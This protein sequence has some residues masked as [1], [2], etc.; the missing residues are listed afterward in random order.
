[1]E[2]VEFLAQTSAE[3]AFSE[4]KPEKIAWMACHFSPYGMGLSNLPQTL[5]EG[6][7]L[8]LNDR[9]PICSHDP[10]LIAAQLSDAVSDFSCCAV[11]LDFQR[12]G[13]DRTRQVV[14]SIIEAHPC[15]VGVS[16]LYAEE[17]DC[18]VFLPPPDLDKPLRD[19]LAPWDGREIWLEAALDMAR[20]TVTEKG[21]TSLPLPYSPPDGDFFKDEALCCSYRCDIHPDAAV[22]T[23]WRTPEDLADLLTQ[24]QALGIPRTI[25]LYQQLKNGPLV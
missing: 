11:L 18:P 4:K 20:F 1:M 5:P 13:S 19:H 22:F 8:I 3:F 6:S 17:F 12:P 7:M 15:P 16:H 25:G 24:A 9:I 10:G 14:Q 21:C 2:K 23:L